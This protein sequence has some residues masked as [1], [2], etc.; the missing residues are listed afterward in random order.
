M[1]AYGFNKSKVRG[2]KRL[3]ALTEEDITETV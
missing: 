2:A 1:G 3:G